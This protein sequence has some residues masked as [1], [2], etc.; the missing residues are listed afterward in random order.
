MREKSGFH[1]PAYRRRRTAQPG[2]R[3]HPQSKRGRKSEIPGPLLSTYLVVQ[4]GPAS[5]V[6][7]PL[8]ENIPFAAI[9]GAP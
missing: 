9:E 3:F 4:T 1:Y 8:S 5:V 6:K 2:T 7:V